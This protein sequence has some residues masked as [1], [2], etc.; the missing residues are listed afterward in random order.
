VTRTL[1]QLVSD[2]SAWPILL[3]MFEASPLDV[4][5]IEADR[6]SRV[7]SLQVEA[8]SAAE[9]ITVTPAWPARCES[10]LE[11]LS[12]IWLG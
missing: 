2:D 9:D 6:D 12:R 7:A 10:T 5:I 4:E 3:E 1:E 8:R 11:S